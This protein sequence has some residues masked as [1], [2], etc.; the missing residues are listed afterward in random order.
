[1]QIFGD[2]QGR[3]IALGGRLGRDCLDI[4]QNLDTCATDENC[5]LSLEE[6]ELARSSPDAAAVLEQH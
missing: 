1:M 3:V 2:G 4:A 5:V 6:P